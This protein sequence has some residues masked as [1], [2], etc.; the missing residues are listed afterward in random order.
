VTTL[1]VQKP[2]SVECARGA[3]HFDPGG[4]VTVSSPG[5]PESR[6][7]FPDLLLS[8]FVEF[9]CGDDWACFVGEK[10]KTVWFARPST[11]TLAEIME[12]DRL[13]FEGGYDPGGLHSVEF[14]GLADGDLLIVYELGLA[15][16][17]SDGT[18]RWQKVHDQISAHLD[19]LGN[20]IAWFR[21]E[22]ENFGFDLADG[23]WVLAA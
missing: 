6:K 10:G 2:L 21:G 23:H 8:N 3:I 18:A 20:G 5:M 9:W 4:W 11:S 22:Y 15:R 17:G 16:V 14:H 12:L 1:D 7:K 13:D 19:H